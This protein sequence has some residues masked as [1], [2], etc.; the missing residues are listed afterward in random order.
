VNEGA[1]ILNRPSHTKKLE[2]KKYIYGQCAAKYRG[3]FLAFQ[4]VRV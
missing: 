2:K 4:N 3:W 1:Q